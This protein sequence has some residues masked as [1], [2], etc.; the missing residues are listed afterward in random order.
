MKIREYQKS[1]RAERALSSVEE[2]F[3][4]TEAAGSAQAIELQNPAERVGYHSDFCSDLVPKRPSRRRFL[5]RIARGLYRYGPSGTIYLC[6]KHNGK[7]VWKSL[8]TSEKARAMAIKALCDYADVQNGNHEFSV[9]PAPVSA[10]DQA[11]CLQLQ[12][13]PKTPL[14]LVPQPAVPASHEPAANPITAPAV[15]VPVPEPLR[16]LKPKSPD[17]VTLNKLVERFRSESAHLALATRQKFDFHFKVAARFF[18]FNRPVGEIR[19][20]D[21]RA[22]RSKLAE[23]RK[24]STVNDI[25]FK[26]LAALFTM[27]AEDGI[28]ERSPLERLKRVKPREPDR[29]E[30]AWGQAQQIVTEVGRYAEESAIILAFAQNFGVGQA[31]IK[32]LRGEHIDFEKGEIN[33]RR[34]KTGK[35]FEIPIFPHAKAFIEKLKAAG[36][37]QVG[38]PVVEWRNPRKALESACERLNVPK[39]EPRAFRRCF[40]VHALEI[41]IEPRLVAKWQGHRDASLIFKVYGKHIDH[42]HERRQAEK[43]GTTAAS[44]VKDHAPQPDDCPSNRDAV[45]SA[46]RAVVGS[47]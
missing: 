33:F 19:L 39:C 38:K 47:S 41:G 44:V 27:A 16:L 18:D 2:H 24:P 32:H 30:L 45:C 29:R 34:K 23:E 35:P 22:L 17:A 1:F 6:R 20:A 3:L 15:S 21:L 11:T 10:S 5:V 26:A 9:V 37:F 36:R 4:H 42:E 8:Q 13:V 25:I 28:I 31:E 43:L 7:N 46:E 12:I 40:I 14:P